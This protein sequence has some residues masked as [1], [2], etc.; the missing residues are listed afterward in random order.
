MYVLSLGYKIGYM[1]IGIWFIRAMEI[2]LHVVVENHLHLFVSI[3]KLSTPKLSCGN[4]ATD[5][6][7][8]G[9]SF[10][11]RVRYTS[12]ECFI[13]VNNKIN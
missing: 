13:R 10:T 6:L 4:S 3:G 7:M 9:N 8:L 12:N 1:S 11:V 5:F 2:R